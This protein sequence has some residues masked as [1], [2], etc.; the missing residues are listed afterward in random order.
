MTTSP[1]P[2]WHYPRKSGFFSLYVFVCECISIS[3]AIKQPVYT[4]PN[5]TA[6]KKNLSTKSVSTS[7]ESLAEKL[8][9]KLNIAMM[10]D[11]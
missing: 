9:D 6:K 2:R 3:V 10:P 8:Q 4:D 1:D 7:P 11:F 5:V